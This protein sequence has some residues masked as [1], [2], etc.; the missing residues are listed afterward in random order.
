V[1]HVDTHQH[2]HLWPTVARVV[3]ELAREAGVPAV[4]L[5]GSHSHAPVGLGVRALSRR[6]R[7]ALRA[8]GRVTTEDYAG[9]DEA[10]HLD[11]PRFRH[12]LAAA[13][14]RGA[15]TVEINTHPSQAGDA[16]LHRFSWDYQ[17]ADELAMLVDPAVREE[18]AAAGFTLSGFTS[19]TTLDGA[20]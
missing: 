9:L 11:G 15:R 18:I 12:V 1:T 13:A 14:G 4:R 20:A 10:G 7:S 2:T 16:D 17:W 3:A 19:L 6:T 5:P 8:V